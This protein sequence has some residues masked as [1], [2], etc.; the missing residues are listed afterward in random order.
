ML[1]V[2]ILDLVKSNKHTF[3]KPKTNKSKQLIF[4]FFF[5]IIKLCILSGL[6]LIFFVNLVTLLREIILQT[7]Y[8][9]LIEITSAKKIEKYLIIFF[10]KSMSVF[11]HLGNF[12]VKSL[13][14]TRCKFNISDRGTEIQQFHG[15]FA[16]KIFFKPNKLNIFSVKSNS[17][18]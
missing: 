16:T 18:L 10:G 2:Q 5:L 3:E 15:I 14:S 13:I 11:L 9:N 7:A 12:Y 17:V 6:H 4:Y 1:N 8:N